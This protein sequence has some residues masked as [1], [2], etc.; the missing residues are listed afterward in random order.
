M[1]WWRKGLLVGL[2]VLVLVVSRLVGLG[3]PGE[4][5]LATL[6][7]GTGTEFALNHGFTGLRGVTTRPDGNLWFTDPGYDQIGRVTP[8]GL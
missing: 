4:G 3:F 8:R 1:H 7:T 2:V 6:S 5:P